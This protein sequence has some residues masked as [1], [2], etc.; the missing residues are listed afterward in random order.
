L[1]RYCSKEYTTA[2]K[3][4]EVEG[5][6]DAIQGHG[7]EQDQHDVGQILREGCP[8]QLMKYYSR[9]NKIKMLRQRNCPLWKGTKRML[10]QSIKKKGTVN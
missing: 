7:D 9:E 6:L 10:I 2:H 3:D 5:I 1:L 4:T 8:P